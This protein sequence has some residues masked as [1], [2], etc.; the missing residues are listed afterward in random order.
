MMKSL[1]Q[2]L[3]FPLF[4]NYTTV[5]KFALVVLKWQQQK[6]RKINMVQLPWPKGRQSALNQLLSEAILSS[7]IT[8][9]CNCVG[10]VFL[11]IIKQLHQR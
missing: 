7:V 5:E 6:F 2:A 3:P 11:H 4:K 1:G 9:Q 8:H 10:H